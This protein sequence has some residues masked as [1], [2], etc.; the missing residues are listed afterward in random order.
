VQRIRL[1]HWDAAEA[2]E[3]AGWL[4]ALGYGVDREP[5]SPAG[6]RALGADPPAAVV[7][8]LGR[9]PSQGRDLGLQLRMRAATRPLPLVYV[10]GK[11]DKVAGVRELLP[12]AV[13]ATWDG[14]GPAL[15]EAI[16]RPPEDPVVPQSVFEAYAGTPLPKKLGI[17]AGSTVALVGA[18]EGF[19][20]TLG[21]LPEG[22]MVRR[23]VGGEPEVTLWF[24]R[25]RRALEAGIEE[26]G[27]G[28]GQGR[29]WIVWPKKASGVAS[30]LTQQVVRQVGLDAGLVDFKVCAV[31]ATWSGLCFTWRKGRVAE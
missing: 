26:M 27:D 24:T 14:I 29:L 31:D 7:V 17:Q 9:L 16:A 4:R 1:V 15:A 19:E 23:E 5:L 11:A 20:A 30:D 28:A 25:S 8:D 2:E 10:G 3:R 13:Y 18:P 22:V 12:D 6:L 21:D